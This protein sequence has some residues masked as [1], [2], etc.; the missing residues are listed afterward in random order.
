MKELI[1][2]IQKRESCRHYAAKPVEREKLLRCLEAARLSPSACNTQPWHITLV[3]DN[4]TLVHE[5]AKCLQDETMNHFTDEVPAFAVICET[6]VSLSP[7]VSAKFPSQT[8]S[9]IDIGLMAAHFCLKA[10]EE[11]LSTCILGYMYE[12]KLKK[13]LALPDD[14]KVR[15]V[16]AVGYAADES[17]RPKKRK[18]PEEIV[19]FL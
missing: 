4:P 18:S 12:E 1:D 3:C 7:K 13:L 19:T 14:W 16:L 17:I 6:P 15:I 2:L 11:G 9:Q 5:T 8:F 10:T